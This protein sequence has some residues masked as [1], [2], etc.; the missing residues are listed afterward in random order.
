MCLVLSRRKNIKIELTLQVA[1]TVSSKPKYIFSGTLKL[2]KKSFVKY[3]L[4]CLKYMRWIFVTWIY[5]PDPLIYRFSSYLFSSLD[6]TFPLHLFYLLYMQ[7]TGNLKH[8]RSITV[9]REFSSPLAYKKIYFDI[10]SYVFS[11]IFSHMRKVS[12]RK[13]FFTGFDI[14]K[15]R[16]WLDI[17]YVSP[18]K[19]TVFWSLPFH[20]WAQFWEQIAISKWVKNDVIRF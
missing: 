6:H 16:H 11:K 10:K 15:S 18:C 20:T 7:E 9:N 17:F 1:I 14:K 4:L 12:I 2:V 13:Q 8:Y 5:M 3:P 19:K